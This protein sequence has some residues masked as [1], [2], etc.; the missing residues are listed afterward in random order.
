VTDARFR[1]RALNLRRKQMQQLTVLFAVLS[2]S[3]VLAPFFSPYSLIHDGIRIAVEVTLVLT[4]WRLGLGGSLLTIVAIVMMLNE[5]TEWVLPMHPEPW[6]VVTS[7]GLNCV[8]L[9]ITAGFMMW[10]FWKQ[11][12]VGPGALMGAIGVYALLAYF[13]SS[14][15]S[16]LEYLHPG[17]FV[18]ACPERP[19]GAAGCVG[20]LG[21]YPRFAYF[22]FVTMTTL[23][24]G[25][26]LPLSRPAEGLVAL[27]AVSGQLFIAVLVGRMVG[28]YVHE[29]PEDDG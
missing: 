2:T 19:G 28:I 14:G 22:S 17:S 16:M 12:V 23:G 9:G 1:G 26:M 13:W 8:F 10:M 5:A 29:H 25:D 24:Y 6:L 21:I 18:G 7:L 20:E 3:L 4:V 11:A 27:A 15:F